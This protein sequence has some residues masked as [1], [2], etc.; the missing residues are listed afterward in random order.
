MKQMVIAVTAAFAIIVGQAVIE[1][2]AQGVAPA[3]RAAVEKAIAANE[4]KINEAFAKRDA[5]TMKTFIADEAVGV[6]MT[7]Y[8]PVADTLKQLPTMDVKISEQN[9]ANFKYTWVDANTV[10]VSYTWT[11]KGTA[12]GQPVPSPAYASTVWTKRGAKWVA[13]FHQESAAATMPMKK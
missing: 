12:M 8:T 7:G 3:D 10:V 2:A 13:L 1:G 6:D 9:L 5:A 11:G 4:Q